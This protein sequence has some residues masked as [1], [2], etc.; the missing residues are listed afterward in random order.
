MPRRKLLS[1]VLPATA[2]ASI[3]M[4]GADAE[5]RL[6]IIEQT[7]IVAV[8]GFTGPASAFQDDGDPE[9]LQIVFLDKLSDGPSRVSKN[10]EVIFLY[11]ASEKTQQELIAEAFEI[12]L[13]R[14]A[15]AAAKS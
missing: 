12:R 7:R 1:L 15:A 2:F 3:A 8:T 14:E 10:G 13:A 6:R 5:R 11:K 9:T 4:G